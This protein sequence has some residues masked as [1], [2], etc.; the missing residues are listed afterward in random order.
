MWLYIG[1][2]MINHS[3]GLISLAAAERGL[4]IM[5]SL[6]HWLPLT[7]L[8]YG[9]FC[10]HLLLAWWGIYRRPSL[11]MSV[12]DA[13]RICIGL[14]FPLLLIGH[15]F[16][17]RITYEWYWLAPE[18]SRVVAGLIASGSEGR[19]LALLAPGWLHG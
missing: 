11:R 6:V 19:Q 2:H 3:L 4:A 9:A 5:V 17:T 7:V 1:A 16:S 8:L 14:G 10:L 18:Y 13:I 12:V 15:V